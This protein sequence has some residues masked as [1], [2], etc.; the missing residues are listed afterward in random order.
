MT[1]AA[2]V[3]AETPPGRIDLALEDGIAWITI[4]NKARRNA[5]SLAMWQ[6]L[7]AVCDRIADDPSVRVAALTGDGDK[8]FASGADISEFEALRH[9]PA[10]VAAYDDATAA[11]KAKLRG[12]PMPTVAVIRGFCVGGGLAVALDTDLRFASEDAR[13]AV[14]AAK[15][16]LGYGFDGIKSLIDLLGPSRAKEVF[17]TARL[18]SA[19]E[20]RDMGLV[21]RVAPAD[22]FGE[23][24][25]AYLA[26][27]AAGAPLTLAAVKQA[28]RAAVADPADRDLDGVRKAVAACFAS[29]DYVEGRR[30][31]MEKR[32]PRFQGR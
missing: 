13:F 23:A 27:I 32:A 22:G 29:Q 5:L 9:T 20:A 14:P 28:A 17:F 12:L 3:S 1:K 26:L 11:A 21:D 31:F 30:A 16:G 18:Y 8:A 6:Q 7:G 15:L 25:R 2:T 24:A 10:A 4:A 19:A